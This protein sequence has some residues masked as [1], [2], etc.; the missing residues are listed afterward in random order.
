MNANNE[1]TRED[2]KI[3]P[4]I[5]VD[6]D[7]KEITVYIE[8][9]FDVDRKFGTNTAADD[10]TWL[11]LYGHYNP[12]KDS[13]RLECEISSSDGSS[14]FDYEATPD[15]AQLIKTMIAE[16]IKRAWNQTPEEFCKV[17]DTN[18]YQ[19]KD[20]SEYESEPQEERFEVL[21]TSD[22]FPDP[23]D[24]YAIWDNIRE[25]YYADDYGKILTYPTEEAANEGLAAVKKAVAD[26]GAKEWLYRIQMNN[27]PHS[28]MGFGWIYQH[29]GLNSSDYCEVYA[30][31]I[32]ADNETDACES[33]F[34]QFSMKPPED[35]YG[36]SLRVADVILLQRADEFRP[37]AWF[38]DSIGFKNVTGIFRIASNQ[39]T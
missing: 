38:C 32:E 28:F 8:T 27:G 3:G 35:Y 29:G 17:K 16:E 34:E 37:T 21:M 31:T 30:G 20:A 23:E 13:L 11:N 14:Y 5:E 15:E 36:R 2:I 7:E 10:D 39:K 9:C 22:A 6:G 1:L 12:Y 26:K 33:L 4:D 19:D 25:E 18:D 24:V